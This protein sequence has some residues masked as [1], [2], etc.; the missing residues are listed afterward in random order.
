MKIA[1]LVSFCDTMVVIGVEMK[2]KKNLGEA[3]NL[4][5]QAD[6]KIKQELYQEALELLLRAI[7]LNMEHGRAF[8]HLAWLYTYKFQDLSK[9]EEYYKRA[10]EYSPEYNPVYLN[11]AHLLCMLNR[12]RELTTLTK[13]A[14]KIPGLDLKSIYEY[15]G[16]CAETAKEYKSAIEQY[17]KALG[18]AFNNADMSYYKE[19]IERCEFKSGYF[20]GQLS[21]NAFKNTDSFTDSEN[22]KIWSKADKD[23]LAGLIIIIVVLLFASLSAIAILSMQR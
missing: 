3:D 16:V 17:K 18:V 20:S 14:E 22:L 1:I 21:L 6:I 11:Y 15:N 12:R 2:H 19:S 8:N 23:T 4:F 9:A 5:F 7:N 13:K 10:L